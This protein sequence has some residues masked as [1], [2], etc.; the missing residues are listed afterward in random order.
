VVS[1]EHNLIAYVFLSRLASELQGEGNKQ[2]AARY[3]SAAAKISSAI[4]ANLLVSDDSGT[5]FLQGLKDPV[6][7]LDVQAYGAMYLE[8]TGQPRA[9]VQVLAFA[10]KH[11]AIDGRSV[12]LSKRRSTYNMTY[13][14]AGPFAG[15]RPYAGDGTPDVLWA[16]GS[17]EMGLAEAALGQDTSALDQNI[18]DWAGITSDQA[19]GPLQADRTYTGGFGVQYHVWPASTAAAWTALADSSPAFFAAPL[20]R[21]TTLVNQ[22][23][24]ER[25]GDLVS[26][27][28]DGRVEMDQGKGESRVLAGSPK[29]TDYTLTSNVTLK[30]GSGYGVYVR[31]SVDV[32]TKLTGYAVQL[33][34]ADGA[35]LVTLDQNDVELAKPIAQVAMPAGFAW[36]DPHTMSVTVKGNAMA[37]GMDGTAMI[38]IPDLDAA[39]AKSSG[40]KIAAPRAGEYG[41]LAASQAQVTLQQMTVADGD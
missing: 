3:Q 5:H 41:L 13:S 35:L 33:D 21:A 12:V 1:T 2:T 36:K 11:F 27:F 7:A 15:Y 17:G 25:G 23:T 16:E 19:Q 34:K 30:S 20:P 8:G 29:E 6:L 4:N 39:T 37:V 9:A 31:A 40:L 14:A 10:Q 22:C 18:A 26:T 28:P 24:V 38:T 32:D